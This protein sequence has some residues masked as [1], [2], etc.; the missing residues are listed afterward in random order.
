[1]LIAWLKLRQRTLGPLLEAN[2]WAINGR[3]KINIP[4]GT[5]LTERAVLPKNSRRDLNDPYED[6]EAAA[7]RR[8][9]TALVIVAS[10]LAGVL[11]HHHR[12][13][14][15]I[16][17]NAD[18]RQKVRDEREAAV[19]REQARKN[20]IDEQAKKQVETEAGVK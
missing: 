6:K 2:G 4:F 10:V 15:W 19:A 12:Q 14:Y 9:I 5:K 8:R 18:T 1:M 11:W 13:G 17:D 16:W 20:L 3:V 7:R